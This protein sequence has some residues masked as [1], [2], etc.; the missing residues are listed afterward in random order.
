MLNKPKFWD[1]KH[2]S[3]YSLIFLPLTILLILINWLSQFIDKKKFKIKTICVGNIY[4]GGTGKTPLTIEIFKILKALKQKSVIIK[5]Y[6]K[7]Q[8]DEQKLLSKIGPIISRNSRTV[9]LTLAEKQGYK[10]AVIDD[11]LQDKKIDYDLKIVCFDKEVF[12]GNSKLLPAGPLRENLNSLKNYDVVFF[13]GVSNLKKEDREKVKKIN[14]N[15]EIF[16]THQKILN[17]NKIKKNKNYLIFSGIGNPSN[18]KSLLLKNKIKVKKTL[19]YPD[20]YNYSL[21]DLKFIENLAKKL[22][23]KIITTEKDYLR[24]NNLD[25]KNIEFI[26]MKLEIKRKKSL[27]QL[28]RK[29]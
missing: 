7:N 26:K 24:I 17:I 15:I 14:N 10:V 22:K 5:K 29:I 27:I 3:F 2:E 8:K 13:N 12:L 20:H 4:I 21:N 6:Y 11:G 28:I 19:V 25:K 18:F 1:R 9:S 16:E 23:L